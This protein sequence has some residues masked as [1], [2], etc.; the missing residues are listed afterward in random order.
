MA[1]IVLIHGHMH[2]AW[3]WEKVVPLLKAKGH[4]VV[5][6]DLPSRGADTS[7]HETAT[8]EQFVKAAE[9]V[10]RAQGEP[11]V[12]VGH[13]A[14]GTVLSELAERMPER[15][16]RLVYV[17]A[18]LLPDGESIFSAIIAKSPADPAIAVV[19]ASACKSEDSL[20]R[21]R[22]YNTS[23]DEEAAW[24][25]SQLCAEPIPPMTHPVRV[26]PERYGRV[27]RAFIQTRFDNAV[28][29]DAQAAMCAALPC[30]PVIV[31][32]TDHSPFLCAPA[33][34]AAHL[35]ALARV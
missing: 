4:R 5:A 31:M 30:D 6:F 34:F 10:V 13:S 15:I 28:P 21:R 16:A 22:F 3:C 11:V 23:S 19:G 32:D 1:T 29:I 14:G 2:G 33:E 17:A 8:L 27:R 18:T 9:D 7:A 12:L 26:T 35:D 20:A 24:A 25:L